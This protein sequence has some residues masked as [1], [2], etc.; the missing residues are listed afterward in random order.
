MHLDA[1]CARQAVSARRKQHAQRS[2]HKAVAA[3]VSQKSELEIEGFVFLLFRRL[4][5]D[6][7]QF[8]QQNW[9]GDSLDRDEENSRIQH[10]A[11]IAN[12]LGITPSVDTE[13]IQ[14]E[15]FLKT[16][17]DRERYR[18]GYGVE[19]TGKV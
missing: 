15:V 3:P 6:R 17:D 2:R 18:S 9:Q 4:L 13:A 7:S 1:A 16:Y 19:L 8:T 10:L 11:E 5:G 14:E 12:F